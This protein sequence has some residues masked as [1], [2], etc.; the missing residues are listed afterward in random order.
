MAPEEPFSITSAEIHVY[1]GFYGLGQSDCYESRRVA[2]FFEKG[3]EYVNLRWIGFHV[4]GAVVLFTAAFFAPLPSYAQVNGA[5]HA[6]SA[7][8]ISAEITKG[9]LNPAESKP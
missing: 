2:S 3:E 6:N 1:S 7:S 8:H 9:R 4:V 5:A